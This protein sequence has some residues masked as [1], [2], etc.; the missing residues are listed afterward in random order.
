MD[1]WLRFAK[2]IRQTN[3][4]R[5]YHSL[6]H[7]R[8]LEA[9]PQAKYSFTTSGIFICV[10]QGHLES[11]NVPCFV[12]D[13][14]REQDRTISIGIL[15]MASTISYQ[16]GFISFI[17]CHHGSYHIISQGWSCANKW[18]NTM[19]PRHRA[20]ILQ[21]DLLKGHVG[22]CQAEWVPGFRNHEVKTNHHMDV[23]KNRGVSPQIIPF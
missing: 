23:S 3:T 1:Y 12:N 5:S 8:S 4:P 11:S 20:A 21:L 17:S 14:L 6:L 22:S 7:P 10:L 9:R 13:L 16:P 2:A 15:C 18:S 19:I